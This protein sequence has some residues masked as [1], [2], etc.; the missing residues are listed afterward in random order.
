MKKRI[1]F[2]IITLSLIFICVNITYS[3]SQNVEFI[4][5]SPHYGADTTYVEDNY[6]YLISTSSG[7]SIYD[8]SNPETPVLMSNNDTYVGTLMALLD[9]CISDDNNYL[10]VLSYSAFMYSGLDIWDVS[11]KASPQFINYTLVDESTWGGQIVEDDYLYIANNDFYI[12][13]ISSTPLPYYKVSTLDL[14]ACGM[15]IV[16]RDNYAYISGAGFYVTVDVSNPDTPTALTYLSTGEYMQEITI[17]GDYVFTAVDDSKLLIPIN[18]SDPNAPY[19]LSSYSLPEKVSDIFSVGNYTY[20]ADT[21]GG[22]R[23]LK[24]NDPL[25]IKEVGYFDEDRDYRGIYVDNGYIYVACPD[26]GLEIFR[27][28]AMDTFTISGTV[29]DNEGMPIKGV[30]IELTGDEVKST[31]TDE[32]GNY[33][34]NLLDFGSN[35]TITPISPKPDCYPECGEYYIFEP[36]KVKFNNL[37]SNKI[38]NFKGTLQPAESL[39]YL[40][41]YPNPMKLNQSNRTIAFKGL[42]K[43][44]K[45]EIFTISGEKVF[46]IKTTNQFEYVWDI[47]NN[48]NEEIASGTYLYIVTDKH[49]KMRKGKI[50]I[51]K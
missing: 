20:V 36:R 10:Y 38:Q 19:Q 47:K 23:V 28:T 21:T 45:I 51:I 37:D 50:S 9:F 13:D 32:S 31:T 40:I 1:G 17:S 7:L 22:L 25:N 11:N 30:V 48:S 8:V 43:N 12:L 5:V 29:M 34:I 24:T 4:S 15:D 41:V 18:V 39:D 42:T 6:A 33:H 16:K 46:E 2:F 27:C 3:D 49:N 14:D 26:T 44:S 35:Y